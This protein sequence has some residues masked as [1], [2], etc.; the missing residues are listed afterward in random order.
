MNKVRTGVVNAKELLADYLNI[1]KE[2]DCYMRLLKIVI[3]ANQF[4]IDTRYYA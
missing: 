4:L 2:H 3:G 1:T